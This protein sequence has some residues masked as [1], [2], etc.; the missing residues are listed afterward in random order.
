[1]RFLAAYA[2]AQK[3][4]LE[5]YLV[6]Q[7]PFFGSESEN[8]QQLEQESIKEAG[9]LYSKTKLDQSSYAFCSWNSL[10]S[11]IISYNMAVQ[12]N[13]MTVSVNKCHILKILVEE[14]I[15]KLM[16]IRPNANPIAHRTH[17]LSLKRVTCHFIQL[18]T[19]SGSG[20]PFRAS[21]VRASTVPV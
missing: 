21:V 12:S 7:I 2:A 11:M 15:S 20:T 6:T 8:Y 19:G 9:I 16:H 4:L 18:H 5:C 10:K 1:M 3:C 13:T 14:L 17:C